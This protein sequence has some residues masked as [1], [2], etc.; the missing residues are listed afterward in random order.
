MARRYEDEFELPETQIRALAILEEIMRI[1]PRDD[2]RLRQMLRLLQHQLEVDERQMQEAMQAIQEYEEAYQKLTSPANRIGVFLDQPDEGVAMVAVGDS[3]YYANIDPKLENPQFKVG[4][5]VKVNEA[6]AV[7]G[8]LGYHPAGPIVKV[9][10]VLEGNRLRVGADPQ[11]MTSRIVFR[12]T[13]LAE[14]PIKP[15][16]EV[17]LE[18]NFKVAIEHIPHQEVRDY[19]FEEVPPIEWSQIGGQEEA[20]R[21]IRETIELPMLHPEIFKRFEK[22]PLK[23]ILLYGPPGCGKT[24]IGKATAYNLTRQY[25]EQIGRPVKEYFMYINGPKILNMWLGETE[26][27]VR[28]IFAIAREKAREGYLVFIFIDEAESILR[29]RSSGRWL[30]ISNTVVPQFCAEMDGL[31]SLENVVVMLTSNRPDYIDPAILRPGRIDRKVKV[32]RPD[33]DATREIFGIYLTPTLPLDPEFVRE[34]DTPAEAREC[35]IEQAVQ[36]LWRKAPDTEFLQVYLRNGGVETL[37]W[38]DM[39]SGALIKSVVDRAKEFAIRRAIEDPSGEHGIRPDDLKRAIEMEYRE[40]EIFP[41][42]DVMEDWLK[43]IDYEPEYVASVKPIRPGS[44]ADDL[45]RTV[46]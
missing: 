9:Q 15:G 46:I 40:N 31:V 18:P 6:F 35:L 45:H 2:L 37:Y 1:A 19:Y 21:L 4:T 28:E 22:Q 27:M 26:R 12:S 5:R 20:I 7:V 42:S 38:R 24:L 8:D 25:S 29:T 44:G 13:D 41:K 32:R 17:R 39:V 30:N 16:D 14:A 34:Y 10:E 36:Y 43:L 23:G 3:E 33:R 11:G